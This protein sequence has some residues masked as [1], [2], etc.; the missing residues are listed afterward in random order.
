MGIPI[1]RNLLEKIFSRDKP[2][3][4]FKYIVT[5]T[6]ELKDSGRTPII[7]LDELQKIKDIKI[8]GYLLYELFNLFISLTKENHSAHVFAITSDSLF[9][10]KVFR[11]TKLYGRARYFLVDDFDYKTTE[12]FLRKHGFSSEEIELTRKYFGG[13]PVFL[14][15]AINNRENL[16][17]FC[18]SQ[19]S[20]RKRQIK[21]IIKERD[22]KILREF[23][24]K[25]EIIIEELDE[26]IENLVENNVLF[27]DPVRGVLKPQS[28]LD[29]LAIREI[30]S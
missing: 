11:E 3:D 23:K 16:K 6:K 7:V 13:K 30:V 17:E 27:F 22:F 24:D 9:I 1:S 28:R 26:E 15:E 20:L 4:A 18:E 19:L 25:E 29:L 12:G 21:E 2:G 14:I 5:L 10:E 8:N